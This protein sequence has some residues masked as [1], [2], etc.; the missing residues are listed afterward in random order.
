MILI[1]IKHIYTLFNERMV[2][3]TRGL[4]TPMGEESRSIIQPLVVSTGKLYERRGRNPRETHEF[5]SATFS[6]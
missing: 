6:R 5:S 4:Q 1:F 3:R 2:I